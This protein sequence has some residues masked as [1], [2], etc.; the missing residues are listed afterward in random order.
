MAILGVPVINLFYSIILQRNFSFFPPKRISLGGGGG[1]RKNQRI[2]VLD[3]MTAETGLARGAREGGSGRGVGGVLVR[4]C[5]S[6][7]FLSVFTGLLDQGQVR[8][9][10]NPPFWGAFA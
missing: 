1:Q 3:L 6:A 8:A 4:E 10:C 9:P 7:S 2:G 5:P